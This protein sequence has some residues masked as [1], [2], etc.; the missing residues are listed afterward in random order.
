MMSLKNSGRLLSTQ[1]SAQTEIVRVATPHPLS[2][3]YQA[4]VPSRAF[5]IGRTG[6]RGFNLGI[7]FKKVWSGRFYYVTNA[8]SPEE[9]H[10]KKVS[11]LLTIALLVPY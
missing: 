11:L 9:L 7:T 2:S 1:S 4:V 8:L 10:S 5:V 3:W 6:G